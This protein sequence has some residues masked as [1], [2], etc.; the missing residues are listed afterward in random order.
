MILSNLNNK[1]ESWSGIR[2]G[3]IVKIDSKLSKVLF[4]TQ[5]NKIR[6]LN[7]EN[8]KIFEEDSK[9]CELIYKN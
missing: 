2:I 9:K 8:D 5:N 6:L 7:L 1:R 4:L 3:D